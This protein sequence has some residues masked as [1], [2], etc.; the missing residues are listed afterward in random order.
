MAAITFNNITHDEFKEFKASLKSFDFTSKSAD[1][2][3]HLLAH[4]ISFRHSK[5]MFWYKTLSNHYTDF[6][7]DITKQA[8]MQYFSKPFSG[9]CRCRKGSTECRVVNFI[10]RHFLNDDKEF[11][12]DYYTGKI[13]YKKTPTPI[14]RKRSIEHTDNDDTIVTIKSKK[15]EALLPDIVSQETLESVKILDFTDLLPV[16]DEVI[17]NTYTTEELERINKIL[18]DLLKI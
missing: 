10:I 15:P 18:D 14:N 2:K 4:L 11:K 6:D 7:K 1:G 13:E 12:N 16:D 8:I 17:K 5:K 3:H 9:H